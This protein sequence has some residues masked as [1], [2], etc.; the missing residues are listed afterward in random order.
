MGRRPIG[1]RAMTA[2]ERKQRQRHKQNVTEPVTKSAEPS[3]E[4]IEA[5]KEIERLR[6]QIA[7]LKATA[8]PVTKPVTKPDPSPFNE[9]EA[10]ERMRV[11]MEA[12]ACERAQFGGRPRVRVVNDINQLL[13]VNLVADHVKQTIIDAMLPHV[14]GQANIE[15]GISRRTYRR[16]L[17]DLHP[18]RDAANSEAFMIFKKLDAK[19]PDGKRNRN[20]IVIAD[21]KVTTV[22][23]YRRRQ[24]ERSDKASAAAKAR[25]VARGRKT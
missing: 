10:R 3:A 2:K 4:L 20:S 16:V 13:A 5:R 1:D 21:D 7:A 6:N 15:R 19:R 8:E 25:A 17:A 22:A 11:L 18:D 9:A 23:D 12:D 24:Q 14:A